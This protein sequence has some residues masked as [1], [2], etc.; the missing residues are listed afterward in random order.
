MMR[1]LL[2]IGALT[3]LEAAVAML[4]DGLE[5]VAPSFLPFEAA[6]GRIAAGMP[7][8]AQP[9]PAADT[10]IEDGWAFRALD[11]VGASAYSPM[12]LA[13]APIRVEAGDIMPEGS[14][15]V[16]DAGLV[17][18]SGPIAQALTEAVPG[19]GVR[20]AGE[21]AEAGYEIARAGRRVTA[22]DLLLARSADVGELAVHAPRLRLVDVTATNGDDRTANLI[23]ES[24]KACGAMVGAV[25]KV[26]RD[27]ASI[28]EALDREASDM[29]VLIGGTG[30]GRTDATAE[31]LAARRALTAHNIALQPG[32]TTATGRLGKTPVVAL[33]GMPDQ[34]FAAFLALVQPVLDRL[35]SRSAR[36]AIV[37]PLRRKIASMV[38]IAEIALLREEQGTWI[39]LAAGSLSLQAM[40][41]ADAWLVVPG[42]SE[43][44][45]AGTPVAAFPLRDPT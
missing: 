8:L 21:D 30:A 37:L 43:G 18:C 29:I 7:P 19:Q 25:E 9:L 15:C 22:A 27:P 2:P 16:V 20:R 3:S 12:P 38:G 31:A 14:D 41:S 5:P 33:P 32:R 4:L 39:P 28:A 45:A 17:D 13:D 24:A 26:A 23:A 6:L 44:Y 34:A 11:L 10:A 36:Q 35:S 42:D 1:T 40:Q